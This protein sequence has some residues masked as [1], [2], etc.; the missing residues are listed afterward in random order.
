VIIYIVCLLVKFYAAFFQH[1][2]LQ[3]SWVAD[4]QG[5]NHQGTCVAY[6]VSVFCISFKCVSRQIFSL[7]SL[8]HH[9]HHNILLSR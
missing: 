3:S 4:W 2:Y 1:P 5:C 9:H 6:P 7:Q 8:F